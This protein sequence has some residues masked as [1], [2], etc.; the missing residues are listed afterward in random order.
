[1]ALGPASPDESNGGRALD[2]LGGV[3]LT[4]PNQTPNAVTGCVGVGLRGMSFVVK[5][6]TAQIVE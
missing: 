1:M 3:K 6:E 5:R 4:N 2:W